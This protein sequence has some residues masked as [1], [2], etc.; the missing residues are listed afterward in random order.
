M[1]IKL[2]IFTPTYNRKNELRD[3]YKSLLEKTNKEF[4]SW[5]NVYK[6]WY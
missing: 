4:N 5:P 6:E 1:K 3:V 2:T